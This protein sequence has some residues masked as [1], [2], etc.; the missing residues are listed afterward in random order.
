MANVQIHYTKDVRAAE[1]AE[2]MAAVGWGS[3]MDYDATKVSR[4]ID[5]YP[6]VAHARASDGALVGYVSAFSDGAFS[7]FVG[8][9]VVHPQFQG[10]GVGSLLL[11]AVEAQYR[12]VPVYAKPFR[13]QKDFFLRNGYREASRP[14]TVVFKTNEV[15]G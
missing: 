13:D 11:A 3:A 12:G 2:L 8:E 6:F 14:M 15:G 1:F 7:T 5:S 9:I 10:Q 4:S